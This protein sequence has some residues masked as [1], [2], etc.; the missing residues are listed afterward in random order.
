MQEE[1]AMSTDFRLLGKEILACDL[2]D[3]R[4]A[5]FGISEHVNPE[6][7]T[8]TRRCL[9]DGRNY[10]WVFVDDGGFVSSLTRYGFNA[11]G[12]I[13]R[14][15]ADV[16]AADIVSEY[17]PQFWGFETKDEWDA[18]LEEM[19]REDG[20]KFHTEL[21]KY[22]RGEPN[23]IRPGTIGMCQAEVAKKLVELDSTLLLPINKDKFRNLIQSTYKRE[24]AVFV[25]LGPMEKAFVQIAKFQRQ[26]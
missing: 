25:P 10:V 3:G 7:S 1:C 15:L 6:E 18:C 14:A 22:L 12:R 4:L 17:E 20:E 9:T 11:P 16:F 19:S 24:H 8:K 21:L 5:D 2:F 23:D 13:L 26:G